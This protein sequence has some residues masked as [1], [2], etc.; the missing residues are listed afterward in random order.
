MNP[1]GMPAGEL[2]DDLADRQYDVATVF[3]NF[4][5]G[6]KPSRLQ[7]KREVVGRGGK[8]FVIEVRRS[9]K[10]AASGR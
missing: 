7:P 10:P 4:E 1:F 5:S 9:R 8:E 2:P 3:R 6:T